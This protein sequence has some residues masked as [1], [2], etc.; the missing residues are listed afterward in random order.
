MKVVNPAELVGVAEAEFQ[1]GAEAFEAHQKEA[2]K[3]MTKDNATKN[4]PIKNGKSR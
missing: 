3:A 1:Y 2:E 4:V